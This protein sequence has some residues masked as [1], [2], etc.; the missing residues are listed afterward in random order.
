M[1]GFTVDTDAVKALGGSLW[2]LTADLDSA[3]MPADLSDCDTGSHDVTGALK[4]FHQHWVS[5]RD[6]LGDSLSKLAQAV[7]DAATD[8]A[9]SDA[10]VAQGVS[11]SE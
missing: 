6:K 3:A 11:T 9:K 7:T 5:E 4:T 10:A 8:Y 2:Q 1:A